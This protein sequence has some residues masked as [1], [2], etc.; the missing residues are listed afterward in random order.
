MK[1]LKKPNGYWTK[2]RVIANAKKYNTRI[3]WR[4]DS[5]SA[6]AIG[7]EKGWSPEATR[8][9]KRLHK[10]NGYW[11]KEKILLD[12][13]KYTCLKD[14]RK[15]GN[16]AYQVARKNGWGKEATEHMTNSRMSF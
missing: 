15:S 1:E 4:K 2:E 5:P 13:L 12:A 6:H 3:E 7:N 9:M 11:T 10:P 14:W 16:S 8:H